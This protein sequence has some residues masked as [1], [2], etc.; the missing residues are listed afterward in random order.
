[1]GASLCNKMKRRF[2]RI[3]T[4]AALRITTSHPYDERQEVFFCLCV[5]CDDRVK[6]TGRWL[7]GSLP[8]AV[9]RQLAPRAWFP[10][11]CLLAKTVGVLSPGVGWSEECV[12]ELVPQSHIHSRLNQQDLTSSDV[13]LTHSDQNADGGLGPPV[14]GVNLTCEE[15]NTPNWRSLPTVQS[16]SK[17]STADLDWIPVFCVAFFVVFVL[18]FRS[19]HTS[20]LTIGNPVTT[21]PGTWR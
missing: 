13:F 8:A 10:P 2:G 17:A 20:D 19:G 5:R 4:T 11:Q 15:V 21:P 6:S 7:L 18:F 3:Q 1:M 9:V 12:Q 14:K 16:P